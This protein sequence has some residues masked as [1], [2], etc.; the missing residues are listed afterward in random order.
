MKYIAF[1]EFCPEDL[2]KVIEKYNAL[3]E[4][5]EKAPEKYAETLFPPHSMGGENKGFTIVE[6]TPEQMTNTIL[7][8]M[9]VMKLK[10]VPILESRKIIETRMK[11]KK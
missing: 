3:L 9:P 8:Y 1:W 2:D 5:R 11:M 6:A 7:H 10:Y 4:G